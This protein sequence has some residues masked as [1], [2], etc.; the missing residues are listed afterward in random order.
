M[1]ILTT[2]SFKPQSSS[3]SS[4]RTSEFDDSVKYPYHQTKHTQCFVKFYFL[5]QIF[6]ENKSLLRSSWRNIF[7]TEKALA[8]LNRIP[9]FIFIVTMLDLGQPGLYK[10]ITIPWKF[11]YRIDYGLKLYAFGTPTKIFV[12]Q[13]RNDNSSEEL[14]DNSNYPI[15]FLAVV[16]MHCISNGKKLHK[17]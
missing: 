4:I 12:I 15:S 7:Y 10:M 2:D 17:I 1:I 3:S 5:N 11:L 16:C 14:A 13:L 9:D 8:N 6:Q